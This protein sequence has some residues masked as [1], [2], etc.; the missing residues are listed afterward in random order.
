MNI[1]E[2]Y[3]ALNAKSDIDILR[4]FPARYESLSVTPV[5]K[6]P[7]DHMRYVFRGVAS[8]IMAI[9]ASGTSIIRF[10]VM[11]GT[12]A[13]SLIIFSQPFYLM[14]I[15]KGNELLFVTYYSDSRKA[16]VVS[17]I[18]D[19]DSYCATTGLK[20]IYSLPKSISQSYFA[21]YIKKTLSSPF[22]RDMIQSSLPKKYI[23]KYQLLDEFDAFKCVHLPRNQKD[24]NQGLRVFKYEEALQY[25]IRSVSLKKQANNLKKRDTILIDHKKINNFVSALSYQLTK[26]QLLAIRDI[27]LDMEKEKVMYR[28]LQGDVGT[29][30]TIVAF[31]SL[32]ANVIRGKQGVLMAPTFELAKQHYENALKVF[33]SYPIGIAF[34]SGSM[35]QSERKRIL[36][37]LEDGTVQILISTNAVTSESIHFQNLGLTIIDEQQRF[38]VRQRQEILEKGGFTDLLMMSATPIP[39]TLSQIVNA[40]IEVSTLT[41]F[42]HGER[43]VK[44]ALIRSTDP[45]LY[46][47]IEKAIIAKRQA[48]VVCPKIDEGEKGN[49]SATKVYEELKKRFGIEK[50][51]LLHGRIKKEEQDR[52]YQAFLSNEKPIL[53]STTIVEVGIDVSSAGLMI[54]YDAN[55]FGLSSLH[56]LRGRIGR[57]GSFALALLVYDGDDKE[58]NDKL[59]FLA[60]TNDGL[61]ISEYDLRLRGSGSYAGERQSGRSELTVCNFVSDCNIFQCARTD[62]EEILSHPDDKENKAYLESLPKE[63]ETFLA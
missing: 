5:D 44:T 22:E 11:L 39:R 1:T 26:D 4:N 35:K 59:N 29:G 53:V 46:D 48:F 57:S 33:A 23:N 24:L 8:H 27:V 20:P 17:S 19:G 12:R 54:I 7:I 2:L 31:V 37:Q 6:E 60:N 32:Y 63:Q 40:D 30:K 41:Q 3:K 55:Y 52:I 50:V 34:L 42:P 38:G 21:N 58:A 49:A 36:S 47:A 43:N 14:K 13:L 62:A 61:K 15:K 25:C 51:Q 10:T 18:T 45:S 9:T 56:Q 28:L 16:F